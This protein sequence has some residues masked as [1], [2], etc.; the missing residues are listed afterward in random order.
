M[1]TLTQAKAMHPGQMFYS[2]TKRNSDG[3]AMR[4]KVNGKV[5]TWKTRPSEVKVPHKRGLYE[6]GGSKMAGTSTNNRKVHLSFA[7]E[8][9]NNI[10]MCGV[11]H[12]VITG[13]PKK[14]TCSRCRRVMKARKNKWMLR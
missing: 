14:V 5:I 10:G 8:R 13:E 1:I 7:G 3:T 6:L 12:A 9:V 4:A 11:Q 2:T